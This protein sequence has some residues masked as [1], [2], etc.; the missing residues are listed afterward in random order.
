MIRLD[1]YISVASTNLRET[2]QTFEWHSLT[3]IQLRVTCRWDLEFSMSMDYYA[4]V[5]AVEGS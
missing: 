3:N 4:P 1:S 2:I 5:G